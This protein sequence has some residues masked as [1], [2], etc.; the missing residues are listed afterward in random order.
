MHVT[1]T[2]SANPQVKAIRALRQRKQREASGQFVIE[3]IRPVATAI[4][5]GAAVVR[6]VVAPDLLQSD[7]ARAL[8][9][10]Q[11]AAGTPVLAVSA[12]VFASL[13]LKDGPQGIAAVVAQQWHPLAAVDAAAGGVWVALDSVA[14]PGNLGTI[15]RTADAVG[16]RGVVLLGNTTDPYDPAALRAS[17]GAVFT[18]RLVRATFADVTA[19]CRQHGVLLVGTSDAAATH[20]RAASYRAP[21]MLLMGSERQG[22]DAAQQAAC[23]VVVHIPMRG[24]SDSLNLAVATGVLLYEVLHQLVP[25]TAH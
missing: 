24:T 5:Q 1:I 17:M 18:Q 2:S 11:Q 6:L 10:G 23:A 20:Y 3:G 19:H 8:V 7:V 4:E 25:P 12:A 16:A 9:A 22:L 21:L 14:D 15:L 13:S